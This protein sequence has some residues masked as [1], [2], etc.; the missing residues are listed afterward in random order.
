MNTICLI[1]FIFTGLDA[2]S[3]L[4]EKRLGFQIERQEHD[5]GNIS[6]NGREVNWDMKVGM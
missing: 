5:L 3:N 6:I 4:T 1:V 2:H